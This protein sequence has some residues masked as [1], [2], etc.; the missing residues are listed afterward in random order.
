MLKAGEAILMPQSAN[1]VPA[2]RIGAKNWAVHPKDRPG[3]EDP[4]GAGAAYPKF[5]MKGDIDSKLLARRRYASGQLSAD[6]I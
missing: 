4:A 3:K 5:A 2:V 1:R 6:K